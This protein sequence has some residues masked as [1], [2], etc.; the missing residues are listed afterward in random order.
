MPNLKELWR[1][2]R[3]LAGRSRF[4]SELSDELR[5][6]IESRAE[7]L[8]QSGV[9]RSAAAARA[10]RELGS[11]MR[12]AEDAHQAWQIGWLEDLISDLQY[13]A[14]ALRRNPGFALAAISCLALGIGADTTIFSITTS[15]LFSLPSCRDASSLISIWEG[16]NSASSVADY[17]FLRDARV[18]DGTAGLNPERQV[19]WRNGDLSSRLYAGVITDDYF[20]VLGVPTLLGR[21]TAPGE[22]NTVVLSH[23][24][25]RTRFSGD[26]GILGRPMV[27]DGR[28][29]T[30][31]GVLPADH[32][33][34]VGFGYSPEI[35]VPV[36]HDDETVQFYARMPRGMAI[37]AARERLRAVFQELDRIHPLQGWKRTN[38]IRVTGVTG[39]DALREGF[40]PIIAFFGMLLIVVGLVLLIACTNVAGL[41]LARASSRSQEL[42]IRL[43][44][45][46]SR[47]R[48]VRHLLAESLMLSMLGALA[49]LAIDLGCARLISGWTLPVPIPIQV[50]VTPDWRLL[51][52]SVC[53]VLLSA[54]ISGLM[55]ALKAVRRDVNS[56]LKRQQQQVERVWGLRNV[57]VTGQIAV[58]TLLLATGFL[59]IHNLLQATSMN[60]GFDI[61]HT[62]WAHMRLVPEAYK[63]Q[64][65]Q[66]ALV[67][68]ALDRIR[69]LP[70]VD[71]AAITRIVPLNDN[72]TFNAGIRTDVSATPLNVV[73]EANNVGPDYFRAVGIPILRGR[74][75]SVQDVK[76]SRPVV[77]V[78]EA[79]ARKAFGATDPVGH[80]FTIGQPALIV[81]VAKD[82]K[83]F[84]LGENNRA[85]V[86][87]PYFAY[88]EPVNLSF[89]V[90]TA[91]SPSG[92]VKPIGDLLGQFDS[93]AAIEVKPMAGALGLAL[94]PSRVGAAA[95]GAMGLLSLALAAIGLYGIL[96]YS[97]SQ[98]TREIGLRIALGATPAAV[99]RAVYRRSLGLAGAGM[100]IGLALAFFATR[101]VA[102]FL[103]PGLS[104]SDPAAFVAVVAVLGA[105]ALF[106]TWTPAI[107]ALRVDPMTALRYE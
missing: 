51:L 30:I 10:R 88:D 18:F 5:F 35:Y 17:K 70:G 64:A 20:N 105:V 15:F 13:A 37:P 63:D 11:V 33:T 42:A 79:F 19:N 48:L 72:W 95:L 58:S 66:M 27:L 99:L 85:A 38:E 6:H 3:Y 100:A 1:R 89:M 22:T 25:W 93:T 43:S 83:Y 31:V 59:F 65:R 24:L 106:A 2:I 44:L 8:E 12:A 21:G 84:T 39:L 34:V 4:H 91:G 98:R 54:S 16:G 53:I 107:R 60:P 68:E 41:L 36:S 28:P 96:L 9:P 82:S 87:F 50:L 80:T 92:F 29:Y 55:P 102:M 62:L 40:G 103:V 46:A 23:R 32:R 47:T 81:G 7:E 56:A 104:T 90:R 71:A 74:D 94:L 86:Y 101:P 61:N 78:N 45:G 57:L 77:I 75:F 69:N 14:R 26:P 67:R 49:G 52:Y 76:G 73:F 97:V